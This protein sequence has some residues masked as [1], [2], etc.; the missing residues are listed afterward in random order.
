MA[1]GPRAEISARIST[2][3]PSNAAQPSSPLPLLIHPPTLPDF[4][5]RSVELARLSL[6]EHRVSPPGLTTVLTGRNFL[7]TAFVFALKPPPPF[8]RDRGLRD[9]G[10][11]A[12]LILHSV[13]RQ[14]PG[15]VKPRRSFDLLTKGFPRRAKGRREERG[16][17]WASRFLSLLYPEIAVA[18]VV[19]AARCPSVYPA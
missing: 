17:A 6:S 7:S 5:G 16:G 15:F 9:G 18:A 11:R 13:P 3:T 14:S 2:K 19:P 1:P 8:F 4:P 10:R 12:P